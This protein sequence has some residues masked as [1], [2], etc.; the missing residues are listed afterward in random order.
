MTGS[1]VQQAVAGAGKTHWLVEQY[2]EMVVDAVPPL[3]P[4]GVVVI[5]F[6]EAAAQEL[7]DRVRK[8]L[9]DIT[10]TDDVSR[11]L[12]ARAVLEGLGAAP[13]GTIHAFA[14]RL[15]LQNAPAVSVPFGVEVV[16]EL[17][18]VVWAQMSAR[19]VANVFQGAK[20][21]GIDVRQLQ[22][23]SRGSG[24][25]ARVTTLAE[26]A[27]GLLKDVSGALLRSPAWVGADA[28]EMGALLDEAWAA[29]R[30]AHQPPADLLR[31]GE[32]IALLA[33]L[34]E[35]F[36]SVPISTKVTEEFGK[37]LS[38]I[39]QL[40]VLLGSGPN[41][42]AVTVPL[43]QGGSG[44]L[45]KAMRTHCTKAG[46]ASAVATVERVERH[47]EL[48]GEWQVGKD[49]AYARLAGALAV[50]AYL[51]G[52]SQGGTD[53]VLQ[54]ELLQKSLHL[55]LSDADIATALRRRYPRVLLDEAQDV[56]ATQR[57]LLLTLASANGITVVG[58]PQQSI[59]GFR[60]A[61]HA[62]FAELAD[63]LLDGGAPQTLDTTRRSLPIIVEAVNAVFAEDAHHTPMSAH[64]D[65]DEGSVT[66]LRADPRPAP[67]P[68]NPVKSKSPGAPDYRLAQAD[69]LADA[70]V[71]VLNDPM[72]R[73]IDMTTEQWRRPRPS[74]VAILVP[75]RTPVPDLEAALRARAVPTTVRTS[76]DLARHPVAEGLAAALLAVIEPDDTRALLVAL[77][78]PLF[79][80]TDEQIT[81]WSLANGQLRIR[82]RD[83]QGGADSAAASS[84]E[85]DDAARTL[86]TDGVTRTRQA[87]DTLRAASAI[88]RSQGPGPAAQYLVDECQVLA[89]LVAA[90]REDWTRGWA[91]VRLL[92]DA[93][94]D[95]QLAKVEPD[96]QLAIWLR[97]QLAA[98]GTTNLSVLN[99][100]QASGVTV[101][102]I[103]QA[104]GLQWPIVAVAA[105][106]GNDAA[107]AALALSSDDVSD[108][109]T[110]L[111][112]DC[113]YRPEQP[114]DAAPPELA[115]LMY[116]AMTR[117]RDHLIVSG[118]GQS[119]RGAPS[120]VKGG[121]IAERIESLGAPRARVVDVVVDVKH[122]GA[123]DPV[124]LH[125][126]QASYPGPGD[127][128]ARLVAVSAS[129]AKTMRRATPSASGHGKP[130]RAQTATPRKAEP[131]AP[132]STSIPPTA[133]ARPEPSWRPAPGRA[134]VV[135]DY[136]HG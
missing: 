85:S 6:T 11:A 79:A 32:G 36:G 33:E 21:N 125:R 29:A 75:S 123:P 74:D 19:I 63:R 102:T 101:T 90:D 28:N 24:G 121:Y 39:D 8:T 31:R 96:S 106:T 40:R 135:G 9:T 132:A 80:L 104:K 17:E 1:K 127:V 126:P 66:V 16:D 84:D 136:I 69:A 43:K 115:R 103:H 26:D 116:V 14:R 91:Q 59:Y 47:N 107:D 34:K 89:T 42:E 111:T 113:S 37:R 38:L 98:A 114:A 108:V 81:A 27:Q 48:V 78:S 119:G 3:D 60:G 54:D 13:I 12:R 72:A 124:R 87:L 71:G 110:H 70:V 7:V 112:N 53:W 58:D 95:R 65:D 76:R 49:R 131:A 5:T 22:R 93:V 64:R 44:L 67:N 133:Q 50:E 73:V 18:P 57:E 129:A 120:V 92:I 45:N 62:T 52:R 97:E 20:V 30:S 23:T 35:D 88:R 41:E 55:M 105:L 117:A 2:V 109:F 128:A 99:E 61:D 15:L 51:W 10:A 122:T 94:T 25:S 130:D 100:P 77:R 83:P 86:A 46:M 56:D 134:A 118:V 82:W 4:Q 68:K